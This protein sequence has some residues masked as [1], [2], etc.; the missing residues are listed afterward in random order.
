LAEIGRAP[1]A[2]RRDRLVDGPMVIAWLLR[3]VSGVE[4]RFED[5]S[6]GAP[7]VSANV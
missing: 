1:R 5:V 2:D 6:Y 4:K 3:F 7:A